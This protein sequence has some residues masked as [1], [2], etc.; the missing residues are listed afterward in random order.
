MSKIYHQEGAFHK[1]FMVNHIN[2]HRPVTHLIA[3]RLMTNLVNIYRGGFPIIQRWTEAFLDVLRELG[4]PVDPPSPWSTVLKG[5]ALY[6]RRTVPVSSAPSK[7]RVLVCIHWV[8]IGAGCDH[9]LV[10]KYCIYRY[11]WD[12]YWNLGWLD[13]A[14]FLKLGR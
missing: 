13:K 4:R 7:H 3:G 10:H 5:V 2:M 6:L 1:I 9:R 8:L 14:M 11:F 12:V